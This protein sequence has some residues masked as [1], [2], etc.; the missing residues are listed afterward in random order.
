MSKAITLQE[1]I[2]D[3]QA[4]FPFLSGQL[5]MLEENAGDILT[6]QPKHL[7]ERSPFY[8]GSV[9]MVHGLRSCWLDTEK[10]G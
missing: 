6:K 3:T 1:F 9:N 8:V 2:M 4:E 5:N 10:T 7:H